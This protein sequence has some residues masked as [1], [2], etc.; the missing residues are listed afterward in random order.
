V[1]TLATAITAV[2]K[3]LN[4]RGEPKTGPRNSEDAQ[5]EKQRQGKGKKKDKGKAK[6]SKAS[7]DNAKQTNAT[8]EK[9]LISCWIC[10]KE[11]YVKNCPL[12]QKSNALEKANN[13]HVGVLRVLNVVI[14]GGSTESQEQDETRLC[15]V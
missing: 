15:S 6:T 12:K 11:H 8:K 4:F 10:A 3:L 9:K 1:Q 5:G 7:E 2:E 14:E 13:P